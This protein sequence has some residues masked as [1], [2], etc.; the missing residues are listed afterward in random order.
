MIPMCNCATMTFRFYSLKWKTWAARR[1]QAVWR[2]YHE[3]KLYKSLHEAEDRL[4]DGVT[5][6]AGSSKV[7]HNDEGKA[8]K[9][10]LL[11]PQKPDETNFN[12][13]D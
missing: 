9:R 3:R 6:E 11:L 12:G 13:E 10:L 4:Q 7:E 5:D 2:R 8:P 1:I